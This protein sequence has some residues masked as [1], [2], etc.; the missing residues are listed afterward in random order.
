[1]TCPRCGT[2]PTCYV[3]VHGHMQCAL[4]NQVI[5]DCCQGETT[6]CSYDP[7]KVQSDKNITS[8]K[9]GE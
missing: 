5:D 6:S 3:Y 8:D 4:C 9:K 1:M 7:W 2:H